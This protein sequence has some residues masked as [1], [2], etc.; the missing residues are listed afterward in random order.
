MK[1]DIK[2]QALRR[3]KIIEGQVRGLQDMVERNTYC[4]DVITQT[5]AVKRALSGVEDLLMENHLGTCVVDQIK[6]G[7]ENKAKAEILT[8]YRLKRK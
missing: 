3:L 6:K 4:I 5:S 1:Q 7:E 2:T 8:V